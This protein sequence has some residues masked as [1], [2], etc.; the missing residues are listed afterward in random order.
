M[1]EQPNKGGR[2]RKAKI[3]N[4]IIQKKHDLV[5]SL[6]ENDTLYQTLKK[7]LKELQ[8]GDLKENFNSIVKIT[9]QMSGIHEK[10]WSLVS[11]SAEEKAIITKSI[12]SAEASKKAPSFDLA[13]VTYE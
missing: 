11:P 6:E 8:K 5:H 2:P 1:E 13:D 9:S 10:Y 4:D 7:L 12:E 3:L